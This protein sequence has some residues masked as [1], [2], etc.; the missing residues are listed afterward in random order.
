MLIKDKE[1]YCNQHHTNK[2]IFSVAL[3]AALSA[4]SVALGDA[5]IEMYDLVVGST[6]VSV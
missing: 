1:T 6:L 3:A 2:K 4:A 5:G